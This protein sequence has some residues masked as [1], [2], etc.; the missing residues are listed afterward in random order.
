MNA[1]YMV[2]GHSELWVKDEDNHDTFVVVV[3]MT[4]YIG[5]HVLK[6]ITYHHLL[7]NFVQAALFKGALKL[8]LHMKIML[9]VL[10]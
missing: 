9:F 10:E 6:T 7:L 5:G 3:I 1:R 2:G 8:K 4:E